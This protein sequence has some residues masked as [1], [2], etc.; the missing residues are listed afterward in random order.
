MIK[1]ILYKIIAVFSVFTIVGTTLAAPGKPYTDEW[2]EGRIK[3]ALDFNSYFDSTD[4]SV[5]VNNGVAT[6]SGEV[7]S[8]TERKFAETVTA[9]LEGVKK[10]SNNLTINEKLAPRSRSELGQFLSDVTTSAII[11]SKLS[12]DRVTTTINL[13]V[14]TQDGVVKLQGTVPSKEMKERAERIALN[15]Q[16]VSDVEN[17]LKVADPDSLTDKV[18]NSVIDA[19]NAVSDAW[20]STKVRTLLTF[21]SE[22]PGSRVNVSTTSGKV[23]LEGQARSEDQK[24]RIAEEVAEVVGVRGVENRINVKNATS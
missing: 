18:E 20:I 15:T 22:F 12:G 11:K 1:A 10:V 5:D 2:V 3:G 23:I 8:E 24:Q 9:R 19:T 4:V 13:S 16:G 7:P 14:D 6:L 21:N 17:D